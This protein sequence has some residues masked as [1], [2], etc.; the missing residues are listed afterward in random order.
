MAGKFLWIFLRPV[1]KLHQ[2]ITMR[3]EVKTLLPRIVYSFTK[4]N[5]EGK[6]LFS[7]IKY[8]TSI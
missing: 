6:Q 2:L 1:F 4:Q 8:V 5:R 3:R 7:F